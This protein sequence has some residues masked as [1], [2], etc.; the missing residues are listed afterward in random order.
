MTTLRQKAGNLTGVSYLCLGGH[1]LSSQ[2]CRGPLGL[3]QGLGLGLETSRLGMHNF[4]SQ[5]G[6]LDV[7]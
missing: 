3:P 6:N 2:G 5:R 7:T 1:H 4:G